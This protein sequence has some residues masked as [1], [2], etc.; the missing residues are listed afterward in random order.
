MLGLFVVLRVDLNLKWSTVESAQQSKLAVVEYH[1]SS[2]FAYKV[3]AL[4]LSLVNC[5]K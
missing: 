1:Q 2:R 5:F 3:L 4:R